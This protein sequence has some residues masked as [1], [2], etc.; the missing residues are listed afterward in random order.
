MRKCLQFFL[1]VV[2]VVLVCGAAQGEEETQTPEDKEKKEAV[3]LEEVVITATKTP[4]PV[5]ESSL[6]ATVITDK[7][8]QER[9]VFR[10]E[11]MIRAVPGAVISQ[12]GSAGGTT[13]L[14]L[15][16]GEADHTQ[17][18]FNGIKLNDAGG[19]FDWNALTVDNLERIEVVRGPMSTL[20]GADAVTGVV[21]LQTKKGV[22]PP[23]LRL[24]GAW[25][26][27]SENGNYQGDN[28]V[29]LLGSYGKFA[30]SLAYSR[31]DDMGILPLNN[32]F[33]NNVVNARFD[34]DPMENLSFTAFT[35]F[36]DSRFG[37]PTEYG[38][39]RFDTKAAGGPGL[40]PDQKN[41][42]QDLLL[43]LR[44]NYWPFE[45]WE[46]ELT[47]AFTR[48]DRNFDDP[49]N[50]AEST[51][52]AMFGSFFSRDLQQRYSL[53]YHANLR[54]GERQRVDSITTLGVAARAERFKQRIHGVSPFFGG[55]DSHIK[56]HRD[57][58][59]FYFQEQLSLWERLFV[60][61]GFRVE[62]NSAFDQVEFI[63]RA[64]AALRI[65]ETD[66][67]LRAAGGRAIK[68]PT[69]LESFSRS[70]LT[71][72]NP[73]L[74]P[75]VN[76]SWEVGADQYFWQDRVMFSVTYFEN[77][78][79]DLITF[80]P[81]PFPL[82]SSFEN[83]GEVRT[84]GLELALRVKAPFGLTLRAAYTHLFQFTVLDDGGV[85]GLFFAT[86]R[87]LLR[88]PR[89]TFSFDLDYSRPKYGLHLSGLFVGCRD[90]SQFTFTPP[91]NFG[92]ARVTNGSYFIVN[93]AGY[94]TLVEN[95][96]YVRKVQLQAR[97][98]NLFDEDYEEVFGYSSPRFSFL[99]GL[100]VVM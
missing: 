34:F 59:A 62:D 77:H 83:I 43:G 78:F 6:S 100:R 29:S 25:G 35:W 97:I 71:K 5:K 18:L 75:E 41:T 19:G 73:F 84:T 40:D 9:Q 4:V 11:E 54:F 76:V 67:T 31:M 2:L 26:A 45:W 70:Q 49:A 7:E 42:K 22:G 21:N 44:G 52:D 17:V 61:A 36:V 89:H 12:T 48:F 65:K 55:F 27:H 28:R 8:I 58:V 64:S 74:K 13:S 38:G 47:L 50:P 88:R 66:T 3:V 60:T 63:P 90:D 56:T 95:R 23:T 93:L 39:N 69:F 98:N 96:G 24:N 14:F 16:G 33:A 10:A 46:N 99:A 72:A 87:H 94:Y 32:R 15:R 37:V 1:V 57:S 86:G 91:F 81:R 30:Y 92:S 79:S 85:G 80:V 53:D 20:Y 68:E 82:L 51:F